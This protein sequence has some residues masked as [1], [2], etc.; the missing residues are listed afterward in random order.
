MWEEFFVCLAIS[1]TFREISLPCNDGLPARVGFDIVGGT[2]P[3]LVEG[4]CSELTYGLATCWMG[5]GSRMV[6]RDALNGTAELLLPKHEFLSGRLSWYYLHQR[7]LLVTAEP[8]GG[9]PP[10]SFEWSDRSRNNQ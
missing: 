8:L 5:H 2:P 10:Y 1:L 7:Y 3:Y 6:V 4:N 9:S